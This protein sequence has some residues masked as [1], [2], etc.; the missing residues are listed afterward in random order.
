MN[1]QLEWVKVLAHRRVDDLGNDSKVLMSEDVTQ[2][3]DSPPVDL[4]SQSK[5]FIGKVLGG[6]T[7]HEK[8]PLDGRE[9]GF[10]EFPIAILIAPLQ[11]RVGVTCLANAI[12]NVAQ[13]VG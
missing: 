6:L 2:A 7:D 10:H 8:I 3:F 12:E 11:E 5:Q 13:S 4:G 9:S 1:G